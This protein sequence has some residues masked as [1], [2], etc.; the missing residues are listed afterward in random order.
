MNSIDRKCCYENEKMSKSL[1]MIFV[2]SGYCE[3]EISVVIV[4]VGAVTCPEKFS[5]LTS[6]PFLLRDSIV[7]VRLWLSQQI[8]A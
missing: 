4:R 7:N 2:E 1:H 3:Y 6:M 8:I 5:E